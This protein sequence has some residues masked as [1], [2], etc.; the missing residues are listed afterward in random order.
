MAKKPSIKKASQGKAVRPD[1]ADKRKRRHFVGRVVAA[2][3][4]DGRKMRLVE[5]F[6]YVDKNGVTWVA[7][8]GSV[9]DGASIPTWL[10]GES[11]G[12]PY[13]GWFRDA[14]VIHDVYCVKRSRT[15]QETHRVFYEMMLER[16]VESEQAARMYWAVKRF[17]PRWDEK[18]KELE[19]DYKDYDDWSDA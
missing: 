8:K 11:N 5:D 3:L 17:G 18:G 1:R 13:C 15:W 6:S 10:W 4:E 19:I 12:S 2:W 16:G 7:P 9:I 14:S